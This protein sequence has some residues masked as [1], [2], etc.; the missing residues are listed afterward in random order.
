MGILCFGEVQLSLLVLLDCAELSQLTG[1]VRDVTL[2]GVMSG[3]S[4]CSDVIV[5]SQSLVESAGAGAML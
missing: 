3:N 4:R 2:L 5:T 1:E